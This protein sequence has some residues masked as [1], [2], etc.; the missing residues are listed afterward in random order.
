MIEAIIAILIVG[1]SAFF[2]AFFGTKI[3]YSISSEWLCFKVKQAHNEQVKKN[4]EK[5]E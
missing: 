1:L 2:G 4:E 3:A 5:K